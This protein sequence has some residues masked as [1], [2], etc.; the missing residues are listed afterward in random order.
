MQNRFINRLRL[1]LAAFACTIL[2]CIAL[3]ATAASSAQI[4]A[5]NNLQ[6][7]MASI[8]NTAVVGQISQLHDTL[9]NH[10]WRTIYEFSQVSKS[11]MPGTRLALTPIPAMSQLDAENYLNTYYTAYFSNTQLPP[12]NCPVAQLGGSPGRPM[13]MTDLQLKQLLIMASG[14][15][16]KGTAVFDAFY[17]FKTNLCGAL[18]NFAQLQFRLDK[19]SAVKDNWNT[20]AT[21]GV[22]LSGWS[23]NQTLSFDNG[24][25]KNLHRTVQAGGGILFKCGS[26]LNGSTSDAL[27]YD[28]W[29][30]WSDNNA[31]PLNIFK[32]IKEATDTPP[33]SCPTLCIPV[34]G[35]SSDA[36]GSICIGISPGISAVTGDTIPMKIGAKIGFK[37]REVYVC[38]PV[39]NVPAPFG[40]A[41]SLGE[42]SD[43]AKTQTLSK[44]QSQFM[45]LLSPNMKA[46]VTNIESIMSAPR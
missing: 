36:G 23:L 6:A 9:K 28:S 10:K 19:Y 44:T 35:V 5:F 16:A 7:T 24:D 39:I 18:Y 26:I 38:S 12:L 14:D 41:Q 11:P 27:A 42:M 3:P 46:T 15:V 1:L 31:V 4:A 17:N 43:S 8:A 30:K 20:C 29:F 34:V 45:N 22:M 37:S 2:S 13:R 32:M 21:D 40:V 33:T 25:K